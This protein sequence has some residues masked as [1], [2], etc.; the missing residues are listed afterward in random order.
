[1][2]VAR[3]LRRTLAVAALTVV[4]AAAAMAQQKIVN[5]GF[6]SGSF[7]GLTRGGNTGSTSVSSNCGGFA[8][9]SGDFCGRLGPVRSDGTL[10]QTC[11]ATAGNSLSLSF[12]L[13]SNGAALND[14]RVF[15]NGATL[16]DQANLGSFDFTQFTFNAT[17]LASDTLTFAFR[18]DPSYLGLDDIS[19]TEGPPTM[20]TTPEP[21]SMALLGTG[22]VGLVPMVRRRRKN[23]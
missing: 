20:T 3:C 22:L 11:S 14:F 4:A 10:S 9:H 5:G 7:T 17:A 6:E 19:V 15:L 16:F 2:T 8:P 12:W 1:M 13:A 23:G 21:S 18:N